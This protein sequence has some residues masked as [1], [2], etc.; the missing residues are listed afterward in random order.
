MEK[1][2]ICPSCGATCDSNL[3]ACPY[4]GTMIEQG[5]EKEY[6]EKL[7][8]VKEDLENLGDIPDAELKKNIKKQVFKVLIPIGIALVLIAVCAV[9]FAGEEQDRSEEM[10]KEYALRQELLPPL[11]A[12]YDAGDYEGLYRAFSELYSSENA[13]VTYDWEHKAFCDALEYV[14]M[15]EEDWAR[16]AEN[17]TERYGNYFFYDIW[18]L[19]YIQ[20]HKD[21]YK[22]AEY[23]YLE[24][25]MEA[26]FGHYDE[27]FQL[28]AEQ[29]AYFEEGLAGDYFRITYADCTDFLKEHPEVR[30]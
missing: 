12:L 22:A 1:E 9:F 20:A 17:K 13:F 23:A 25:R 30:K 6:M 16:Y 4:C 27:A 29:T 26:A 28:T 19:K 14:T 21:R 15:A 3:S 8:D 5:A 7:R 11:E 2:I 24:E 10:R 18:N